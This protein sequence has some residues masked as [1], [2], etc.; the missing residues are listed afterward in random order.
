MIYETFMRRDITVCTLGFFKM[1]DCIY[2]LTSYK[3]KETISFSTEI[4]LCK[5]KILMAQTCTFGEF[6]GCTVQ[7]DMAH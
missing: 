1:K 3:G 4:Y 6:V 7:I 5:N 2:V